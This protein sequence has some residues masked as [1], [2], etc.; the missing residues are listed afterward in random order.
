VIRSARMLVALAALFA[1]PAYAETTLNVYISSTLR[2]DVMRQAFDRFEAANPGI[3]VN[4]QLGGATSDLQAQYLNTVLSAKDSSL[5]V[6]MLDIIRP[7]QFAATGWTMPLNQAVGDPA[8]FLKQYLPVYADA[9]VVDGKLVALPAVADAQFLYYRK[10]LLDKYHLPVPQTWNELAKEAKTIQ[11]GEHDPQLQGLSFQG[12]PIEGTVCTFLVP[13]WSQGKNLI[14]NGHLTFDHDAAVKSL[15]L[16]TG[17]MKEGVAPRNAA[18]I[19][20][21]Q[22]RK[23]F[24]AGKA[25]FAVEWSYGWNL[26]QSAQ[27]AVKDKVAVADLPAVEGG[28]HVTC[29]GGWQ[30]GVSAYSQH[31]AEAIRLVKFLSSVPVSTLLADKASLLPVFPKLYDDPQLL[32]TM[33]WLPQALPVAEHAKSRPV[34]PYYNDVSNIIRTQTNAVLAGSESADQAAATMQNALRRALH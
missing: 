7:A 22:T 16:W 33:P 30:W 8:T 19:V 29:F 28:K 1:L 25:I 12:A 23:D 32:R 14:Q 5:D 21:D 34:T 3:K 10:D 9:D 27:S 13:Y 17:L 20:T 18:E 31:Q 15:D 11:A 4:P 26:F 6:L 2:P 24:E